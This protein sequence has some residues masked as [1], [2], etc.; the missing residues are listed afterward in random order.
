MIIPKETSIK[1][2]LESTATA[3]NDRYFYLP[4]W[5]EKLE[6]GDYRFRMFNDLPNELKE[7]IKKIR[8]GGY[9]IDS[10]FDRSGI[11]SEE[12]GK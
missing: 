3:V 5:F 4:G 2:I 9:N 12:F 1:D 6:E 10:R 7:T 8:D 11:Q